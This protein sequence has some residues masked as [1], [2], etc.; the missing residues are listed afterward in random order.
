MKETKRKKRKRV[1][2]SEPFEEFHHILRFQTTEYLKLLYITYMGLL[3]FA[4]SDALDDGGAL[5]FK[6]EELKRIIGEV[7]GM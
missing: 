2:V 6:D 7:S 5:K 1:I 3:I 4:K